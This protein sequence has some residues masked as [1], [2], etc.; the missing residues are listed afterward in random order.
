MPILPGM[1]IE[2][3]GSIPFVPFD[4]FFCQQ[5]SVILLIILVLVRGI[6]LTNI[7]TVNIS[8]S[9]VRLILRVHPNLQ[10]WV[11]AQITPFMVQLPGPGWGDHSSRASRASRA[12]AWPAGIGRV[13]NGDSFFSFG[14]FL[15]V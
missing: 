10:F 15:T 5:R 14:R 11:T 12:G 13:G 8:L 9:D 3:L 2:M 6:P 1:Q 4:S 7:A